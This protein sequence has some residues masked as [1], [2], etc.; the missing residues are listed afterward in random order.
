MEMFRYNKY[1]G[2]NNNHEMDRSLC[3]SL[4][5]THSLSLYLY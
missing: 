1:K 3:L 5:L 2:L 4:S